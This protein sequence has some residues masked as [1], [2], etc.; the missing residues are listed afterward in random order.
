MVKF[1]CQGIKQTLGSKGLTWWL[2]SHIIPSYMIIHSFKH[3]KLFQACKTTESSVCAILQGAI[4]KYWC[5]HC[6]TNAFGM[7]TSLQYCMHGFTH[8][9]IFLYVTQNYS[10]KVNLFSEK[11]LFGKLKYLGALSLVVACKNS[12]SKEQYSFCLVVMA[13]QVRVEK[14]DNTKMVFT[15]CIKSS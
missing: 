10:Q 1:K 6:S 8:L 3:W 7:Y 5:K 14:C 15:V 2:L 12:Q 9:Q 4:G 13:V 11:V